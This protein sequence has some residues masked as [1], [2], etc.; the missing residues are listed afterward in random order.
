M[1]VGDT[2]FAVDANRLKGFE[3]F[4][5][6]EETGAGCADEGYDL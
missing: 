5:F 6:F 4:G 3:V 1:E 2:G